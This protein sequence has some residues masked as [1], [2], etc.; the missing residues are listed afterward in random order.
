MATVQVVYEL[1]TRYIIESLE[2][3]FRRILADAAANHD[4]VDLGKARLSPT[5]AAHLRSYY[6]KIDFIN[7]ED[8]NLDKLL[9]DNIRNARSEWV[10]YNKYDIP[11][12]PT[13]SD[14]LSAVKSIEKNSKMMIEVRPD[15]ERQLAFVTMLILKRPDLDI[16]LSKCASK[17]YDFVYMEWLTKRKEHNSYLEFVNNSIT[18]RKVVNGKV[19]VAGGKSIDVRQYILSHKVLPSDFGTK[20]LV[21]IENG[22]AKGEWGGVVL[23]CIST[24]MAP[25]LEIHKLAEYLKFR[26]EG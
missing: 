5:N 3:K 10:E 9:K 23:K 8:E 24:L 7:S 25:K 20:D 6:D 15:S 13:F 21:V 17:I 1:G 14:Y 19:D 11:Q 4:I 26:K 18:E 22:K 12:S 16:D 2:N